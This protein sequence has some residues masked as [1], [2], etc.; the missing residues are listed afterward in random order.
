MPRSATNI[1]E[2]PENA[3]KVLEC[4]SSRYI[5]RS[6][7]IWPVYEMSYRNIVHAQWALGSFL[8]DLHRLVSDPALSCKPN[9]VY[10]SKKTR[11]KVKTIVTRVY[12]AYE[13]RRKLRQFSFQ[14]SF[15]FF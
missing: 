6:H 11:V 12:I 14:L 13:I 8:I 10:T 7:S 9:I 15:D 3:K 5:K 2:V 4:Y 1:N